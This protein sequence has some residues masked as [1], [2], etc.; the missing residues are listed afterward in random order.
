M[1]CR[2]SGH[3][4]VPPVAAPVRWLWK[5]KD[6]SQVASARAVKKWIADLFRRLLLA[7]RH[8]F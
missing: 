4:G 2:K 7:I 5:G 1:K 6:R 8:I 3:S